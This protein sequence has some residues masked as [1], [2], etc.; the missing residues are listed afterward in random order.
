MVYIVYEG[1]RI[2]KLIYF[3]YA[4]EVQ[5]WARKLTLLKLK[6]TT[7]ELKLKLLELRFTL[8]DSKL[9]KIHTLENQYSHFPNPILH[10]RKIVLYTFKM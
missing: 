9:F 6:L 1:W 3:P 8:L 4:K 7:Y 5:D 2:S 10:S